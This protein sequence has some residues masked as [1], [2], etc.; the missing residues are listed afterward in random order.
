[1]EEKKE[2]KELSYE[3]LKTV[4][5]QLSQQ[6]Q[7]LNAMLRQS[8]MA[9]VFKRLDYLFKILELRSCFNSDFVIACSDEIVSMMT[10][11][12]ENPENTDK[13][14]SHEQAE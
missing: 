7:Q 11:A 5:G 9:N 6:N 14:N 10:P 13:E 4:A 2:K 12:E 1:M 8:N 3:E